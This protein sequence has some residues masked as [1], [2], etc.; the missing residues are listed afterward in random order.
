M[1]GHVKTNAL[2]QNFISVWVRHVWCE[3]TMSASFIVEL[4]TTFNKEPWN[5]H[6]LILQEYI[7]NIP[8]NELKM[9]L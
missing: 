2:A 8:P 6:T 4:H 9:Y 5:R 7:I 1:D 3:T